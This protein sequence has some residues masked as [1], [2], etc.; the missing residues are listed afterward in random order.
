MADRRDRRITIRLSDNEMARL[1]ELKPRGTTRGAF[2]RSFLRRT[3]AEDEIASHDE[4]LAILTAQARDGS[5]TAAVAL[6]RA[7][8]ANEQGEVETDDLEEFLAASAV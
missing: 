4:S 7:L 2:M 3:P 1:D 5:S 6:E 8:R